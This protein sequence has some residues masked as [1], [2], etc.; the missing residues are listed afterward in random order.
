MMGK[1]EPQGPAPLK[2][3]GVGGPL[4]TLSSSLPHPARTLG[5]CLEQGGR[6]TSPA[7]AQAQQTR[8]KVS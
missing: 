3:L 5:I 6:L 4:R 2:G 8:T 1:L 7:A